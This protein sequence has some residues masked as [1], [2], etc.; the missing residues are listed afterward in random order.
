MTHA[1]QTA[2]DRVHPPGRDPEP[3]TDPAELAGVPERTHHAIFLDVAF[4][5]GVFGRKVV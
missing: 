3:F 5:R 1:R 4:T 2:P